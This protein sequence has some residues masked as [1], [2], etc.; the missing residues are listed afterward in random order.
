MDT[1]FFVGLRH[2]KQADIKNI[3]SPLSIVQSL[4]NTHD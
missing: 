3:F 2:A 1:M 4:C